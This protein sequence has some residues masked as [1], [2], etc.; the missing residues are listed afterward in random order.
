MNMKTEAKERAVVKA[1]DGREYDH[2][3][4]KAHALF[5]GWV[6]AIEPMLEQYDVLEVESEFAFPL[7][8]PETEAASRTFVEAGKIDGI[9]RHRKSGAVCV[10]EHKTTGSALE[11]DSDYWLRLAMDTQISKY[12]LAVAQRGEHV[13]SALYDV[14]RKPAHRP[15]NIPIL[16]DDGVK[17]VLDA[18]GDRVRTKDGKKFRQTGDLELGYVLQTRPETPEEYHAR[19]LEELNSDPEKYFA[20]R[21]IPRTDA[22]ILEY[23]QD[24]WAL[25]QQILY[26]RRA[27]LWP[28]NPSACTEFGGCEFFGLCSGRASVDGITFRAKEKKHA[29]LEIKENGHEFLTNSRLS[30]LRKC[31][32]YHFL[33]FENPTERVEGENESLVVGS[34]FHKAVESYLKTYIK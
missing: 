27:K 13:N 25:S 1:L 21:E 24:A 31:S 17:I 9:L 28:R 5:L 4:A 15:S 7:L 11:S 10:L 3:T 16:D 32:R 12:V 20:R 6:P 19:I 18:N 22:A 14:V 34:I 26:F 33:K 29:E 30:A 23:M 8:N 2:A